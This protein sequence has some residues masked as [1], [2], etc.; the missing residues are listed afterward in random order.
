MA[1][2][3]GFASPLR[4]NNQGPC[5]SGGLAGGKPFDDAGREPV[6]AFD[7][8]SRGANVLTGAAQEVLSAHWDRYQFEDALTGPQYPDRTDYMISKQKHPPGRN[9]RVISARALRWSGIAHSEKV[10]TT[11]SK[12]APGKSSVSESPI[13]NST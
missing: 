13:R 2:G 5:S 6:V 7:P 10:Q 12:L 3:V 9:T 11:V 8:E 1:G 4:P